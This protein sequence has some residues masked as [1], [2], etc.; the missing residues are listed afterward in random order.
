V[1][2]LVNQLRLL[3]VDA[4]IVAQRGRRDRRREVFRWRVQVAPKVFAT[5]RALLQEMPETDVAVATHWTTALVVRKLVDAGRARQCAYLL[6]D[7]EPWFVPESDPTGRARVKQTYEMIPNKIVTSD[8]LRG[9]LER[10]GYEARTIPLGLDLGFF[11]PRPVER[12]SRPV[13]LAM[14][15][16]RTPRRGFD[17]V[18]ASLA[19]VHELVPSVDIVL[20]GENM[21]AVKLPFPYRSAGVVTDRD[22]LAR[23]YSAARVHFDGSEFQAFGLPALE[24][25]ACGA[26]SVL[27]AVGGVQEYARHDENCLLV[28]PDD[29]DLAAAAIVAVLSDDA[30]HERLR[31]RGLATSRDFSMR[32]TARETADVL[33]AIAGSPA[34]R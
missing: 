13:V 8:W 4:R 25:M 7:Y 21:G 17:F 1:W 26:V 28:A 16:P 15:R 27:T 3:G 23:L 34:P 29:P 12:R 9:L 6:Q 20:F 5:E 30:L 14:A 22:E 2:Q 31:T 11:Y 19:K 10:H 32:R 33:A 18:V 24:A